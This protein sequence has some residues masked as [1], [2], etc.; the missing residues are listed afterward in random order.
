MLKNKQKNAT[1]N[2]TLFCYGV[3]HKIITNKVVMPVIWFFQSSF[4]IPSLTFV[5]LVWFQTALGLFFSLAVSC[6][7]FARVLRKSPSFFFSLRAPS[8]DI[9]W[10]FKSASPVKSLWNFFGTF[11]FRNSVR[12]LSFWSGAF[13]NM[14]GRKCC[15]IVRTQRV[16]RN[17][18][19]TVCKQMQINQLLQSLWIIWWEK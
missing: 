2:I 5:P 12:N 18:H 3:N 11:F 6:F 14:K 9:L 13:W 17:L 1:K 4:Y 7:L 15:W 16:E 19:E 10:Y 8:S